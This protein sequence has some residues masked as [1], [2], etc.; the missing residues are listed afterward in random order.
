MRR[1][2]SRP[3]VDDVLFGNCLESFVLF[4]KMTELVGS[5]K[6]HLECVEI[7]I[8]KTTFL[9]QRKDER[10]RKQ[11]TT[12]VSVSNFDSYFLS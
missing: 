5:E 1:T 8:L 9:R 2:N 4:R 11:I 7:V 12:D 3:Y 6:L 10:E